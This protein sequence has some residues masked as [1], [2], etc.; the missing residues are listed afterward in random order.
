MNDRSPS[1][2]PRARTDT[3][4]PTNRAEL[5]PFCRIYESPGPNPAGI[6]RDKGPKSRGEQ[7][8]HAVSIDT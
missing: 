5:D 3:F 8:T 7:W 1:H 2:V 6:M 4:F